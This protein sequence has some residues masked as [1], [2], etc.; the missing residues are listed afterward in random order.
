MPA[1]YSLYIVNKAG[2]LIFHHDFS[3]RARRAGNDDLR[4]ASTFHALHVMAQDFCPVA[5]VERPSGITALET[6]SFRLEC[7]RTQTGTKFMLV[8]EPA[9]AGLQRLLREIYVV[10]ADYVL[11]NPFYVTDMPV[12]CHLF[13]RHLAA[14]VKRFTLA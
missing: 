7:F 5:D 11:K 4:L 2:G 3:A 12:R 14:C 13:D 9:A 6:G 10:Y 1:I 8:A